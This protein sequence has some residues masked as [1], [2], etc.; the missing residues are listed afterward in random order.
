MTLE[1]TELTN[2]LWFTI[3][4]ETDDGTRVLYR[5][6]QG[7]KTKVT[8][9]VVM[10]VG[11]DNEVLA[12]LE[13]TDVDNGILTPVPLRKEDADLYLSV[14]NDKS[15]DPYDPKIY[16]KGLPVKAL[17]TA[18]FVILRGLLNKP[19][20]YAIDHETTNRPTFKEITVGTPC[21]TWYA[22]DRYPGVVT[23]VSPRGS[24]ITIRQI[25]YEPAK[26]YNHFTNQEN[27]YHFDQFTS[28]DIIMRKT[29]MGWSHKLLKCQFGHA[30]AYQDPTF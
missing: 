16:G 28:D 10:L 2:G 11:K 5:E 14:Y 18:G 25:R 1:L 30:R 6:Q 8:H 27:I 17:D 24:Q 20:T 21:T 9:E 13:G 22:T 3:L 29:K 4:D 12:F 15:V 19:N 7:Y 26:G 23:K